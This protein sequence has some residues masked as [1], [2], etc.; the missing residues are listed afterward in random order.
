M[1]RRNTAER[2]AE[3]E[4]FKR[5]AVAF[6]EFLDAEALADSDVSIIGEPGP[7]GEMVYSEFHG[8]PP[9]LAAS[10]RDSI[11]RLQQTRPH[12]WRA[13]LRQAVQDLLEMSRTLNHQK[14]QIVDSRLRAEGAPTLSAM[15]SEIWRTIPRILNR[16]RIQTESEYYLLVARLNDET[17]DDLTQADRDR[18]AE[19]VLEFEERRVERR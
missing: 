14:V 5:F 17:G 16:G 13:G 9:Q 3:C 11:V 1:P 6:A 2:D 8:P 10:L 18:L 4:R 12:G 15:R 7:D 19:M